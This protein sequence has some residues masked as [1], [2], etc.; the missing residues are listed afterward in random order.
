MHGRLEYA[1]SGLST[2]PSNDVGG[3]GMVFIFGAPGGTRAP[4]SLISGVR[5]GERYH[6]TWGLGVWANDGEYG[7]PP[8]Y[9]AFVY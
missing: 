5:G 1:N 2:V 4:T 7:V 8:L 9:I 3:S 6:P